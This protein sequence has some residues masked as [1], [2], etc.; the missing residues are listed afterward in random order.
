MI[1]ILSKHKVCLDLYP[2]SIYK[3]L[4]C[5]KGGLPYVTIP[6][7]ITEKYKNVYDGMH[8]MEPDLDYLVNLLTTLC[9]EKPVYKTS[10]QK[11]NNKN[12]IQIFLHKIK[13]KG[14]I[15]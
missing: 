8:F 4:C 2:K 12:Q 1:E 15:L 10:L 9:S 14:M 6:S 5:A 11:T 7:P 13:K 3:M